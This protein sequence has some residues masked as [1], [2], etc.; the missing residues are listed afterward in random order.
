ML[1]TLIYAMLC[2]YYATNNR[3]SSSCIIKEINLYYTL[4][5]QY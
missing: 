4:V 2:G 5:L 3:S 1:F